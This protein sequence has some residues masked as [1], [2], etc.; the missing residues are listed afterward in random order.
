MR[1]ETERLIIRSLEMEDDK[2]FIAMAADGSL[3]DIFGDCSKCHEW[4]KDWIEEARQF[5]QRNTPQKDYLAYAVIEKEGANLVGSVGCSYYEDTNEIGLVYFIGADW[6][7][8]GYA[9]EAVAAYTSWFFQQ[10][11][12]SRLIATVRVANKTSCRTLEKVGFTQ[13]ETKMYQDMYDKKEELYSF[14]EKRTK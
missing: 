12:I 3:Y 10:Y 1:I 9:T 4:M 7:K 5:E 11:D 13:K 6:R 2:S 8:R 14:Y